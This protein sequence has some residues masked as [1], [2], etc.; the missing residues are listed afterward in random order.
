MLL[1][2]LFSYRVNRGSKGC[3]TYAVCG[4]EGGLMTYAVSE[5]TCDS[6]KGK[7]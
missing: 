1:V 7:E 3:Q 4:A 6:C 2:H 5:V